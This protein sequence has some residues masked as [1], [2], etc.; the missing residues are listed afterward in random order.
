M[1]A[2]SAIPCD[3]EAAVLRAA[4]SASLEQI[5][6]VEKQLLNYPQIET[7]LTHR[8]APGVYMR[9]IFMPA[10][11]IIIGHEHTT[12]H[13]NVIL[14]GRASVVMDGQR[15][16]L[17]AGD[18]VV[19]KAGVRKLLYIHEDMR[20]ATIHPTEE[21]DVEKLESLLI[22]KSGSWLA[23]AAE[24]KQLRESVEKA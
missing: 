3:Q 6:Q 24:I 21:T 9:E 1:S 13:L 20:W 4:P 7:K 12:S 14:S 2:V 8:F 15:H 17:K 16:E 10:H 19:S 23:H 18:V 11:S 22:V 5:E